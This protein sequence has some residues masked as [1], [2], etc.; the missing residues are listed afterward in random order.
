MVLVGITILGRCWNA[1]P[2]YSTYKFRYNT[3]NILL[4]TDNK[5]S[6]Q[7]ARQV[8]LWDVFCEL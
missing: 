1:S 4:Y 5:T 2:E 8:E 7:P 3:A 6:L